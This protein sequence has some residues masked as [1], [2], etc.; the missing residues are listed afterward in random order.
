LFGSEYVIEH[1]VL[2]FDKAIKQKLYQEYMSDG[3]K[4]LSESVAT[5]FGGSYLKKRFADII[6]GVTEEEI[7]AD[8][9]VID[10]IERAGL[11]LK[12]D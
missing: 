1:C 6:E 8:D 12:V 10:I 2:A 3:L 7:S 9:I 11:S 5:A 4:L